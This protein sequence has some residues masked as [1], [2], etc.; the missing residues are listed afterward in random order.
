MTTTEIGRM[1]MAR[2]EKL[3]QEQ[4]EV[5]VSGGAN[6]DTGTIETQRGVVLGIRLARNKTAQAFKDI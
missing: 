4:T 1:V 5:L 6:A 3:E 2:L